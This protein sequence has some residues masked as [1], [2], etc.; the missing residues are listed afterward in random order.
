MDPFILSVKRVRSVVVLTLKTVMVKL[1]SAISSEVY[2]L[3][4]MN[5]SLCSS[6]FNFVHSKPSRQSI[7]DPYSYIFLW[8]NKPPN[9]SVP[10]ARVFIFSWSVCEVILSQV[11]D[12]ACTTT[13]REVEPFIAVASAGLVGGSVACTWGKQGKVVKGRGHFLSHFFLVSSPCN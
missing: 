1:G 6:S 13:Y 10:K 9:A 7:A 8:A 12:D 11:A 3:V 2:N 5:I 4:Q